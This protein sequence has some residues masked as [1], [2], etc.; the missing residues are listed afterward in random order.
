MFSFTKVAKWRE[1]TFSFI[2]SFIHYSQRLRLAQHTLSKLLIKNLT[3]HEFESNSGLSHGQPC[4]T[5]CSNPSLLTSRQSSNTFFIVVPPK[6]DIFLTTFYGLYFSLSYTITY[7][8]FPAGP[9]RAASIYVTEKGSN[10]KVQLLM[11]Q[12]H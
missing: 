7:Y 4:Q 9:L 6:E 11:E 3:R 8:K 10:R 12:D 2:H 1:Y 5:N